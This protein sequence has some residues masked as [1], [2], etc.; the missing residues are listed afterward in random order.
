[1]RGDQTRYFKSINLD[2]DEEMDLATQQDIIDQMKD[3]C[4][5]E[6][7]SLSAKIKSEFGRYY[8]ECQLDIGGNPLKLV[9]G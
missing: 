7:E 3:I 5:E 1:M 9:E 4:G 8:R 6:V 2:A